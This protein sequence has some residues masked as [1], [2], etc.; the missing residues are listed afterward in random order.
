MKWKKL[1][2]VFCADHNSDTMVSYGRMPSVI[3][4]RDDIFRIYFESRNKD[5]IA[6]PYY[7]EIDINAPEKI[8]ELATVPLLEFGPTGTFDDNGITPFSVLK[9]DGQVWMY[10]VG[11]NL[12]VK[13]MFQN[14][15]GLAV[16]DDGG[17][18]FRKLY[19]GP[20]FNRGIYD[21]YFPT[22]PLVVYDEGIFKMWYTSF[23]KWEQNEGGLK[24]YYNIKYKESSDG[25]D[26]SAKP[27]TVIDFQ[28]E[29][30]YAFVPRGIVKE[31]GVYSL[32]YSFRAQ[33][34]A[35]TYRIGYAESTD[36][37]EWVRKDG[38]MKHFDVSEAGWDSEMV[39]Y[40]YVFKHKGKNYMLYNGNGYG[41]TGFGLAVMEEA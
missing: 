29:L 32:W 36:G 10:Y 22:G 24:H 37:K 12:E 6:S 33:P 15:I 20:V 31:D 9:K 7:L 35:E 4:V 3:H 16:S 38:L 30:E 27:A 41:R 34:D 23:E 17:K 1:G 8:L 14:A 19:G 28:N 2:N 40:P 11:W 13:V 5:N 39:C 18:T 25:I 26:W 21:I